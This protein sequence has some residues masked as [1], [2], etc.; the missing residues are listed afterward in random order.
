M[1]KTTFLGVNEIYTLQYT[2]SDTIDENV[3]YV[4]VNAQSN[5]KKTSQD[6]VFMFSKEQVVEIYERMM[7]MEKN[8]SQYLK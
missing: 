5:E 3:M 1:K 6:V 4:E 2:Y 7:E 8:N